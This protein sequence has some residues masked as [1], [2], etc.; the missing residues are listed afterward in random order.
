MTAR[1]RSPS[2]VTAAVLLLVLPS[3]AAVFTGV[4]RGRDDGTFLLACA[5]SLL[6]MCGLSALACTAHRRLS[7]L[8]RVSWALVT[9]ALV[10][11]LWATQTLATSVFGTGPPTVVT[12]GPLAPLGGVRPD[13]RAFCTGLVVGAITCWCFVLALGAAR[14]VERRRR[15]ELRR[16]ARA[17]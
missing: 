6:G 3:L 7:L 11:M 4:V 16:R 2:F 13:A 17:A 15:V 14:R 9:G 10:G 1:E 12:A 8:V 5:L